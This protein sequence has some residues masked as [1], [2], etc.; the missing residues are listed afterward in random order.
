M[1]LNNSG[2]AVVLID[3]AFKAVLFSILVAG[4]LN[5]V[6]GLY[7]NLLKVVNLFASVETLY[8]CVVGLVANA[9]LVVLAEVPVG[10]A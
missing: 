3:S 5:S 2:T 9:G 4:I 8:C 7:W 6:E 1:D 10:F